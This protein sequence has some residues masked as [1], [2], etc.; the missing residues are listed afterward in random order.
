[1][2]WF[3]KIIAHKIVPKWTILSPKK[4]KMGI[5]VDKNSQNDQAPFPKV[6]RKNPGI[7]VQRQST[8]DA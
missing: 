6:G 7:A 1:M 4:T 5:F 3:N 2:Y 8:G